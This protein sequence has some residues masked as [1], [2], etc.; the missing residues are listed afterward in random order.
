MALIEVSDTHLQ[1]HA[2]PL[3]VATITLAPPQ[4]P[5]PSAADNQSPATAPI[6]GIVRSIGSW[7]GHQ[8]DHRITSVSEH[9]L[10]HVEFLQPH[11]R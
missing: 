5:Q 9:W 10:Q 6:P 4:P 8:L 1:V 11:S 2:W 7:C 3:L